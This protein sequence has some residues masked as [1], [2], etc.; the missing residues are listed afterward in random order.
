MERLNNLDNVLADVERAGATI[1]EEKS[2]WCWNGLQ[3]VGFF[4]GEASRRP[5]ASEDEMV[6]N[7]PWC[8]NRTKC[9]AIL[10]YY[11]YYQI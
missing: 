1:W 2:N 5:H 10:E 6:W 3:I 8:E 7:W 11:T 4:W 9:R